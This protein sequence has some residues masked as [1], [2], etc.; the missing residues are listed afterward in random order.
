M[1][2]PDYATNPDA[3][4]GDDAKWRLGRAPDYSKTREVYRAGKKQNHK[5]GS[6]EEIVEN[7]VK[8]WEIEASFKTDYKDWRTVDQE[9]Y[10]FS[11]NGGP[12]STGPDMVRIGTYNAL[13]PDSKFYSPNH[14]DYEQS[15]KIFKRMMPRFA[16]EVTE[17]YSG[18]PVVA[19]RWRHW[20]E[21]KFDYVGRNAE[22]KKV[23]VKAH[24][25]IIDIEGVLVAKVNDKLQ[26]QKIDTWY[27]PLSFFREV[28]KEGQEVIIED[29][30][31]SGSDKEGAKCP[32]MQ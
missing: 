29:D 11:L 22:G 15:H 13:L 9:V 27:D 24:G 14:N 28:T 2:L 4:L 31:G 32:F 7:L 20:G 30:T 3:V 23:R 19:F 10:T 26:I 18:P 25:G 1:S 12:P 16:W 8:N 5:P 6:L 17:V 21:M